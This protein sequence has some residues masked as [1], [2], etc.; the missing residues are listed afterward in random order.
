MRLH[1]LIALG[2][3]MAFASIGS[4][5][6]ASKCAWMVSADPADVPAIRE[7]ER[8]QILDSPSYSALRERYPA[9]VTLQN[10]GGVDTEIF[11]P[12]HGIAK[13]NQKRVLI[14]LHGGGFM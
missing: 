8:R 2:S 13:R 12:S 4:P 14:N 7:C 10:L 6:A 9:Q 11:S 5:I 3:A 1:Q